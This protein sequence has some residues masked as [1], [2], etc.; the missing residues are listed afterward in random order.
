MR[1]SGFQPG[2][3][4]KRLAAV[5]PNKSDRKLADEAW[6][7]AVLTRD[8]YTCQAGPDGQRRFRVADVECRGRVDP[9]HV[10]PKGM[11]PERRHEL[12]NGICLCRCHHDWVHFQE[13]A[14]ARE[15]GLLV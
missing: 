12:G 9:H 2:K 7:E 3:P 10:A 15:L 4:R 8:R 1:R 13:P 6:S 14:R 11:N 5:S